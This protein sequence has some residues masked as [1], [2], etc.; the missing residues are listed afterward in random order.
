VMRDTRV[1]TPVTAVLLKIARLTLQGP[2]K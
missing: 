1:A 2:E